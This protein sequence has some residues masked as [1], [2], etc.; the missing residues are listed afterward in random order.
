MHL[1]VF[2][3][4]RRK[5]SSSD[6]HQTEPNYIINHYF[7]IVTLDWTTFTKVLFDT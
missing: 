3:V 7:I 6:L 2:F 5:S 1:K 4:V